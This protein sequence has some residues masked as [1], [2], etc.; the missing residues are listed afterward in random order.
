M[1]SRQLSGHA[2]HV[3][4]AL[5]T[6]KCVL[7]KGVPA[8]GKSRLLAEIESAFV[9]APGRKSEATRPSSFRR[10]DPGS[11]RCCRAPGAAIAADGLSS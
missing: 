10:M 9:H 4:Q 2:K 6:Q 7:I 11:A 8:A 3:L 1:A 5:K